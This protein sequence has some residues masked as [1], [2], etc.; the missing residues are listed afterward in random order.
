MRSPKTIFII[1]FIVFALG[2]GA[3]LAV[4]AEF[5]PAL[6]VNSTMVTS[7]Q[8]HEH[9]DALGQYHKTLIEN[10]QLDDPSIQ[11]IDQISDELRR[12][13]LDQLTEDTLIHNAFSE[14]VGDDGES[15]ITQKMTEIED[16]I[17]TEQFAQ[18]VQSLYGLNPNQ[19]RELALVPQARREV[20]M[21][22]FAK[23]KKDFNEWITS[24]RNEANVFILVR[25][26]DWVEGK[27]ERIEE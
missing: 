13:T 2:V 4:R 21:E 5:F 16:E 7:R 20:V 12:I 10:N 25:G 8:F 22:Q 1:F 24:L 27:V 14:I 19:F 9:L 18:S 17:S 11:S 6:I 15:L 3:Y 23:N 26:F